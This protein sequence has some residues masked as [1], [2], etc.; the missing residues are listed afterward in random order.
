MVAKPVD[1]VEISTPST[2]LDTMAAKRPG[3][4]WGQTPGCLRARRRGLGA[5]AHLAGPLGCGA[6][7][8]DEERVP[9]G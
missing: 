6:L 4:G 8:R 9:R 2:Q 1:G 3:G 5:A 7:W